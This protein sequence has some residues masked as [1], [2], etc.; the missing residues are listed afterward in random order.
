MRLLHLF[1]FITLPSLY[2]RRLFSKIKNYDKPNCIRCKHYIPDTSNDFNSLY[3]KCCIF[4]NKNIHS[5]DITYEYASECRKDEEKCGINGQY[6]EKQH[7]IVCK[8]L[9]H[10]IKKNLF[11]YFCFIT[12]IL[13]LTILIKKY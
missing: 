9:N 2:S 10:N 3:N 8:K 6:F 7:N 5:G 4:G 12:I 1:F 13:Q 11:Y